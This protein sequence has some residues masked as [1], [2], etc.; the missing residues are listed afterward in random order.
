VTFTTL[1]AYDVTLPIRDRMPH[2]TTL[3]QSD[4]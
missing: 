3:M 1:A 4:R 2:L